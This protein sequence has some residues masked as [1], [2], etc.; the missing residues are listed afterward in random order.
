MPHLSKA[1][2]ITSSF[3]TNI[4]TLDTRVEH[5]DYLGRDQPAN[6]VLKNHILVICV[7]LMHNVAGHSIN[8]V[9]I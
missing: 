2:L 1:E 8:L 9:K 4:I 6:L 3:Y 7:S 5:W